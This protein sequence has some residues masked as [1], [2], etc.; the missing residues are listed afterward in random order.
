MKLRQ[1]VFNFEIKSTYVWYLVIHIVL[2]SFIF[3]YS[4]GVFNTCTENVSASLNWGANKESYIALFSSMIPIG[5]F[6]GSLVA[7]SLSS[8]YGRRGSL[9]IAD[10]LYMLGC[11]LSVLPY[12]VSFGTGRLVCGISSG[13]S[14]SI[15]PV[16]VNEVTPDAMTIKMGP[17][18]Q[19]SCNAALIVAYG[20]GLLLPVSD[21]NSARLNNLWMFMFI[22]PGLVAFYQFLYF[23]YYMKF[24]SPKWYLDK[25]MRRKAREALEYT[26]TEDGIERGLARFQEQE[27]SLSPGLNPL[28]AAK[29]LSFQELITNQKYRKMIRIGLLLGIIQQLSGVNANVFYSTRI[30]QEIGGSIRIARVYTFIM[31]I[32]NFFS[33]FLAIPLLKRY[34]RKT[35]IISGELLLVIDLVVLGIF[36][37]NSADGSVLPIICINLFM[38]IFAYSLGATLMAY[39]GEVCNDKAVA[40]SIGCNLFFTCV[41]TISFP[42]AVQTFGIS[43]AFFFFAGSMILSAVYSRWDL[44]ETK[45]RTKPEILNMI[46]H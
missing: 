26:S 4:L 41:V 9:Q 1:D 17:L 46:Y 18:V 25:G 6:L 29:E 30:F 3:S 45:D 12:T 32:V 35:L 13:L 19:I 14:L 22:F 42:Y 37:G 11:V 15:C 36:S 21:Y 27:I 5:A 8:K 24:D 38:V 16:F 2:S 34:G 28:V 33:G 39:L 10:L 40:L 44:I 31:G 7:G 23:A 43:S 20:F